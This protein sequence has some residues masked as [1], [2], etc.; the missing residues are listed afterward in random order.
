M[1][2][3]KNTI[4]KIFF[5]Q[6]YGLKFV[7]IFW[8]VYHQKS[9]KLFFSSWQERISFSPTV[10]ALFRPTKTLIKKSIFQ[11]QNDEIVLLWMLSYTDNINFKTCSKTKI[12]NV[13]FNSPFGKTFLIW[14]PTVTYVNA[15][16]EENE[17]KDKIFPL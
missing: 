14:P 9:L 3:L 15:V 8:D 13:E 11:W 12:K 6:F 2:L 17:S 1:M 4:K 10:I 16:Y 5:H 7:I